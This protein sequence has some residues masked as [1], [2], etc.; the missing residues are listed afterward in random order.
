VSIRHDVAD[1]LGIVGLLDRERHA[2]LAGATS[3]RK[4]RPV[5]PSDAAAARH[6]GIF[7]FINTL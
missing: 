5:S 3:A 2:Q 4:F 6:L 7:Y 1:A